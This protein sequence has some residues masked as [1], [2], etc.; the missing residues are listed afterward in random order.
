MAQHLATRLADALAEPFQVEDQTLEIGVS[1]GIALY[2]DHGRGP[3][4]L[5]QHADV[6]MYQAKRDR[7]R[8]MIYDPEQD[9]HSLARLALMRDLR[10]ALVENQVLLHYQPK[11]ALATMQVCGVE[12]LLRWPHPTQGLIP[13]DQFI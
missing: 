1:I 13:P 2:P 7:L 11:L 8:T 3:Q 9:Q 5:L 4:L 12:A 6:A 10:L